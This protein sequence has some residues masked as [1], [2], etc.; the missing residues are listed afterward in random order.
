M[1][2]KKSNLNTAEKNEIVIDKFYFS[3]YIICSHEGCA[4]REGEVKSGFFY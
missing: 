3:I 1:I 4:S 2:S